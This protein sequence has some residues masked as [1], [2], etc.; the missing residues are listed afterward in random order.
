M[1]VIAIGGEPGTGK[2]SLMKS[3]MAKLGAQTI[4]NTEKLVPYTIIENSKNIIVLGRYDGEGYAQGTDRMSMACQPNVVSF[5]NNNKFDVVLFEGDRLFNQSFLEH[6]N[7][8]YDLSIFLLKTNDE[9]KT[10]RYEERGS[11]QNE[12]WL[13]GRKKKISNICDNME[14]KWITSLLRNNDMN[15]QLSNIEFILEKLNES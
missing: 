8:Y 14:L 12:T 5:L 6:C 1:K 9:I 13:K 10:Q 15:D 3:L 4:N 11:D 7:K 2:S